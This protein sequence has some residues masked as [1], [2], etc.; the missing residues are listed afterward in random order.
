[1]K[2]PHWQQLDGFGT[3]RTPRLSPALAA[4]KAAA[5]ARAVE[6]AQ[7]KAAAAQARIAAE[8][9]L[10]PPGAEQGMLA[11]LSDWAGENQPIVIGGAAALGLL[12]ILRM[13]K[14]K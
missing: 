12:V 7:A 9:G 3:S 13:R 10:P 8:R 5:K 14:K 6:A 11:K 2:H 1:M 4:A